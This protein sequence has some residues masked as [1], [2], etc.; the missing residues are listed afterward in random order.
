MNQN[1]QQRR[2][3]LHV[4]LLCLL[5]ASL[6]ACSSGRPHYTWTDRGT[7]KQRE[8]AKGPQVL[9]Q[10]GTDSEKTNDPVVAPGFLLIL[11]SLSDRK[12][13]GDFR[14]DFEGNLTLPYDTTVNTAGMTVSQLKQKLATQY[15]PFFKSAVDIDLRVK[16][17]VYWVDVR[18]LV[19]TAGRYLVAPKASLD[20]VIALAGGPEK[21]PAP[22]YARIQ[23][24]SKVFVLN[25]NEY[26]SEIESRTPILGWLGGEVVFL[27][28]DYTGAFGERLSSSVSRPPIYMLGAV[29]KPGEYMLRPGSDFVDT[30]AEAN[31]FTEYADLD[32]IEIV[33]RT[34]G[35]KRSYEFSWD[36][37][38]RAPQPVEG[39]V[40]IVHADQRT[41]A[42]RKIAIL[43]LVVSI[44]SSA[45]IIY[46]LNRSNNINDGR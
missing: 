39:D 1:N 22:Q 44:L 19:K 32:R 23:K 18:G 43:A 45:A 17:Q 38:Q 7:Q 30:L 36:N 40:I 46:E 5:L 15:R 33:R 12:L 13:N 14:V 27:Q 26:Y 20:Q 9:E 11:T 10:W 4:R 41:K 25:L 2:T 8:A 28:K 35:K 6:T 31:G 3:P 24:G 42:D 34:G 16:E 29:R 21:D 37:F